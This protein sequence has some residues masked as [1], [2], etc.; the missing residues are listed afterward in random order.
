K[1]ESTCLKINQKPAPITSAALEFTRIE[2]TSLKFLRKSWPTDSRSQDWIWIKMLFRES[3][4]ESVLLRI[5]NLGSWR[6]SWTYHT[7]SCWTT[8]TF[9]DRRGSSPSSYPAG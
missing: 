3:K 2:K 8:R 1:G 9:F 4:A 7:K 6:K 5:L